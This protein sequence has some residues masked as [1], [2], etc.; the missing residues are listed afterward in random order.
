MFKNYFLVA[1]R[2]L[3]KQRLHAFINIFGL[4]VAVAIS[5]LIFLFIRHEYSYDSFHEK[6]DHIVRLWRNLHHPA[7]GD[8]PSVFIP[9]VLGETLKESY[10]EVEY[11]VRLA[12]LNSTVRKGDAA[13]SEALHFV[14]QQFFEVFSFPI[15][16][17]DPNTALA[18]RNAIVL[19]EEMASKYF[20]SSDP[21]GQRLL[22]RFP[23]G[24]HPM[25][26]T[27]V[28]S[29]VPQNSSIEFDFLLNI[30]KARELLDTTY[31][32]SWRAAFAEAYIEL[33]ETTTIA[34]FEKKLP[35]LEELFNRGLNRD[36]KAT[37]FVQPLSSLHLSSEVNDEIVQT[38]DP[39]YSL[40]LSGLGF[41]LLFIACVNF[42]THSLGRSVERS[43]EVGVRKVMGALSSQLTRQ[44]LGEALLTCFLSVLCGM[45]LAEL[46][47]PLFNQLTGK[48]LALYFDFPTLLAGVAILFV[49]GVSAGLYPALVLPRFQPTVI[50]KG[51]Q[52][53]PGRNLLSKALLVLQF[54]MSIS[55][56]ISTLVMKQQLNYLNE[57]GL[58]YDRERVV[59]IAL[60]SGPAEAVQ[61][62][63]RYKTAVIHD[64]R[65]LN[66][67]ATMTPFSQE[68]T[69]LGYN[70]EFGHQSR[71]VFNQ[72]TY[73]YLRTM[74]I[75]LVEGRDFS[76]A[77]GTDAEQAMIVNETF[78]HQLGLQSALTEDLPEQFN[79]DM[80]IIGVVRDFHFSSLRDEIRPLALT[81]GRNP[82]ANI[83]YAR[84]LG[85]IF[86]T[87]L[88]VRIGRGEARPI[89]DLLE[90]TWKTVAPEKPFEFA[91]LDQ[92]IDAHYRQEQRWGQ[93]VHYA[94][95]FSIV[96]ACLGLF[97]LATFT[98]EKR[99]REI[100]VR[101]VLGASV[102][103]ITA[104]VSQDLL[105]L[106]LSAN[107]LS[108]P[109]AYCLLR[110]WLE[111]F[112][113]RIEMSLAV[114][115]LSSLI[116]LS[117]AA[118]TVS[119]KAIKAALANPVESLRYE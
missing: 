67:A 24:E 82:L 45:A 76:E 87:S 60:N 47:L 108:W 40:I 84:R 5:M 23:D 56:I 51:S 20:G 9:Y 59:E 93:I 62:F 33:S 90:Q 34:A 118:F 77:F 43:K 44:Y 91:F 107:I 102:A 57:K 78:V 113:Y 28:A 97:G 117:I 53:I 4:S 61:F 6:S 14:S 3:R 98:I 119:Y 26:V 94:S 80:H 58:G 32:D 39:R 13:F 106:V 70:D 31:F 12:T 50:F 89:I 68:W 8:L 74:G 86:P 25:T 115:V 64:E 15:M 65:V 54:S 73:G 79:P 16:K 7:K 36:F 114:F 2:N 46:M 52:E 66:M 99:V 22:I 109:A 95:I 103:R 75:E 92:T 116:T 37:L 81:L 35:S 96:I 88:V 100:A 55:L 101:K 105:I 48:S 27:A 83:D 38:S 41:L 71:F 17:G 10:S 19:T 30:E 112:A 18:D 104:L 42:I 110:R 111:D 85:D 1:L 29:N 63:E 21:V 49:V 72:V 69:T 11:V